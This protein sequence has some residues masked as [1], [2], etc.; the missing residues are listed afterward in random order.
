[1]PL[2]RTQFEDFR[3]MNLQD[4]VASKL[5]PLEQVPFLNGVR[6][7]DIALSVGAN[8]VSHKLAREAV[9]YFVLKRRA[10]AS[11]WDGAIDDKTL[12]LFASAAVTV[13]L[14]VF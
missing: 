4:A 10:D 11:I 9:G 14:W 12:T 3:L 7:N 6:L 13:D 8:S 1:M 2:L 5:N